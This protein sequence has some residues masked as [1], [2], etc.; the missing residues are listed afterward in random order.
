MVHALFISLVLSLSTTSSS[1]TE[2]HCSKFHYEEQLLEKMIRTE[3]KVEQMEKRA[4]ETFDLV[5]KTLDNLK[6]TVE[7][8]ETHMKNNRKEITG[9]LE[10]KL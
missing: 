10:E 5:E 4:M 8:F 6:A 2:P 9:D 1:A 7:D 3:F